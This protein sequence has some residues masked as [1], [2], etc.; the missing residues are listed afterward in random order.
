MF[1]RGTSYYDFNFK[2]ASLGDSYAL[3]KARPK[4]LK[5]TFT[6]N[7]SGEIIGVFFDTENSHIY[8]DK[9]CD[10]TVKLKFVFDKENMGI[11]YFL[12]TKQ[13]PYSKLIKDCFNNGRLFFQ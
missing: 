5:T 9:N 4:S 6:I 1:L 12:L 3:I 2:N 11:S 10:T 7:L 8:F 13:M